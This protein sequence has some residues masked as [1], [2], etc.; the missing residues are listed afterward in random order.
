VIWFDVIRAEADDIGEYIS[1]LSNSAVLHRQDLAFV[2]WG[3]TDGTHQAR[4]E[5]T[6]QYFPRVRTGHS[7]L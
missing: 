2:V 3:V 4:V 6:L 5:T 1:A 7:A